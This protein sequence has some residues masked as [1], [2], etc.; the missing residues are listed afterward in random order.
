[1][2]APPT[3]RRGGCRQGR[4]LAISVTQLPSEM[5]LLQLLQLM[6]GLH[7]DRNLTP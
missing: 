7:V 4:W 5:L 6:L 2:N 3:T 1:M